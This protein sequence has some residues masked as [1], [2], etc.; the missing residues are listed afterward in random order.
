MLIGGASNDRI[1]AEAGDNIIHDG[2]GSD[3]LTGGAGADT[4]VLC[5]DESADTITDFTPGEDRLDLLA[6]RRIARIW[7][8]LNL[9]IFIRFSVSDKAAPWVKGRPIPW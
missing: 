1:S 2:S 4:F 8:S 9:V 7:G 6:W 3:V 5:Y